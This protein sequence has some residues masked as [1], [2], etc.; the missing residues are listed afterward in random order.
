M[1][2]EIFATMDLCNSENGTRKAESNRISAF[3]QLALA[4]AARRVRISL[5][6]KTPGSLSAKNRFVIA[7]L[8][9]AEL[10]AW[11]AN[12]GDVLRSRRNRLAK[13]NSV[14]S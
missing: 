3:A 13:T 10:A 1:M 6:S 2:N 5:P 8:R 11:Q 7:A 12:G 14:Q 9:A 4:R